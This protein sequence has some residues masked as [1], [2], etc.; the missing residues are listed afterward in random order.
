M[1]YEEEYIE[2][3]EKNNMIYSI[4]PIEDTDADCIIVPIRMD[5]S[6]SP[7]S[8]QWKIVKRFGTDYEMDFVQDITKE[9]T[10]IGDPGIFMSAKPGPTVINFPVV[11]KEGFAVSLT[12]IVTQMKA[13]VETMNY[14]PKYYTIAVPPLGDDYEWEY[15]ENICRTLENI[16]EE[17]VEFC[18]YPEI[19]EWENS[20][21]NEILTKDETARAT[22]VAE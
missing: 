20:N 17:L 3:K 11:D 13:I 1:L 16:N 9:R 8:L 15:I 21:E 12:D 2:K 18:L 22:L 10:R 14:L 5:G 6:I 4:L 7:N 19:E